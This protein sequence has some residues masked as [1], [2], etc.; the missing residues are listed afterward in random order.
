MRTSSSPWSKQSLLFLTIFR[1]TARPFCRSRASTASEKAPEPRERTT[2]YRPANTSPARGWNFL[3]SSSPVSPRPRTTRRW[4]TP[5]SPVPE[6]PTPRSAGSA[7]T[8][9]LGGST[10]GAVVSPPAGR[11]ANG[12]P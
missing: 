10:D 3:L 1:H 5:S 9:A 6:P 11:G 4:R 7:A 12:S 2:R 8:S